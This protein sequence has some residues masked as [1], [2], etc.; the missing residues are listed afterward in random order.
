MVLKAVARRAGHGD[1]EALNIRDLP[2]SVAV[3]RDGR[4]E[5]VLIADGLRQLRLELHGAS[6]LRGPVRLSMGVPSLRHIIPK[7]VLLQRL[8]ALWRLHR[9]PR[10]LFPA[11]PV[12]ARRLLALQA[13]EARRAGAGQREIVIAVMGERRADGKSF[14]SS[15]KAVARLLDLAERRIE[16]SYRR[17]VLDG[18]WQD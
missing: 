8:S 2:V 7:V 11:D 13:F 6:I 12:V 18:D 15:R 14:D 17:F 3:L 5:H 4:S 10:P 1:A 16:T 9:F